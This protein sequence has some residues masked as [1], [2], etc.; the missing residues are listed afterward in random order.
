VYPDICKLPLFFIV[1]LEFMRE[2]VVPVMGSL[3]RPPC[4]RQLNLPCRIENGSSGGTK[5]NGMP[6]QYLTSRQDNWKC[7]NNTICPKH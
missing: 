2:Y 5:L 7:P 4:G 3:R 6:E 1:R